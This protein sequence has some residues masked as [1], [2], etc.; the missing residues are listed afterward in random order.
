MPTAYSRLVRPLIGIAVCAGG[1]AFFTAVFGRR[2]SAVW[3]PIAFIAIVFVVAVRFGTL[4]GILGS[5]A[6]A[7]VFA[8]F[9]FAPLGRLAVEDSAAR[10]NI[11]WLLL[12]GTVISFL[13]APGIEE[14]RRSH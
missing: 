13:V 9:L 6:A 7:A 3:L 1:A 11:G 5:L 8:Y 10:S 2:P 12:G 4:V 14:K